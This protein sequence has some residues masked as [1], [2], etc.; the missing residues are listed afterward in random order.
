V[1]CLDTDESGELLAAGSADM[2]LKVTDTAAYTDKV[3]KGHAGPILSL[4]L[5]PKKE[6]LASAS[7]DGTIR[8]WNI[9]TTSQVNK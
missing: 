4:S 5:D 6:F 8:I 2:T 7:C 9:G 3:F 1:T